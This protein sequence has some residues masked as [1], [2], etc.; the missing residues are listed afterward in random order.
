VQP[1]VLQHHFG[2]EGV[3]QELR[4]GIDQHRQESLLQDHGIGDR[5]RPDLP[6]RSVGERRAESFQP[7][8][9]LCPD[10]A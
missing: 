8:E 9:Q 6:V 10:A 7:L 5:H 4:P 1:P 3:Q 2:A